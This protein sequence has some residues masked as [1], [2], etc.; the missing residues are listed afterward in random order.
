[1]KTDLTIIAAMAAFSLAGQ[2]GVTVPAKPPYSSPANVASGSGTVHS[3]STANLSIPT[4]AP[5]LSTSK[6]W[7]LNSK[8]QSLQIQL[9]ATEA[10]KALKDAQT[11]LQAEQAALSTKCTAAGMILDY[12]RDPKSANYQDVICAPKPKEPEG[13]K[14]K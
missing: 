11:E 7:R 9:E 6:L 10:A 13:K 1:M 4:I 12:D 2:Q 3:D 8:V 5:A 14:D